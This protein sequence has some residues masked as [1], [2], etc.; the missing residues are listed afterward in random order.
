MSNK[1]EG[2][3][4][5][6]K[7]IKDK[8]KELEHQNQLLTNNLVDSIWVSNSATFEY[9][10]TV[11]PFNRNDGYTAKELIGR[12]ILEKLT[13]ASA[14]MATEV[15]AKEIDNHGQGKHEARLFEM[16][17]VHKNGHK[18][19]VE[20]KAKLVK[21]AGSPLKIVGVTRDI[22]ARKTAELQLEDQNRKLVDA[23]AEKERLMKEIKVLRQLLPICSGCK[24]I[25]DDHDKWWPLDAYV[26]EHTDT[27]FTHTICP[28]CKD[29]FYPDRGKKKP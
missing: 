8:L 13:P 10:Y 28:D 24:R 21:E 7:S 4:R 9:E 18:Y 15:L 6:A 2:G 16:E 23:L 1:S 25:R 29:V 5:L 22:T 3:I 27:D 19:W 11:P 17:A 12:S 14:K 26:R 20:I